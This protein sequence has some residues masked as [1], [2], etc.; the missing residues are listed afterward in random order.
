MAVQQSLAKLSPAQFAWENLDCRR[1]NTLPALG[2]LGVAA[3]AF[4]ALAGIL[5]AVFPGL[6]LPEALRHA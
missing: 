6:L 3:G 1:L 4:V 2:G 5:S